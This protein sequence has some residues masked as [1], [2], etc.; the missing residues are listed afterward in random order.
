[1]IQLASE[2]NAS[3]SGWRPA[4]VEEKGVSVDA[5]RSRAGHAWPF[6][7]RHGEKPAAQQPAKS[8]ASES[9]S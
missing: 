9:G 4:P 5:R 3:R 6:I 7:S 2:S 1:M 8:N